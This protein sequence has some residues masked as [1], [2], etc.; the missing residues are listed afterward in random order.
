MRQGGRSS[1]EG[2]RIVCGEVM[3]TRYAVYYAPEPQSALWRFGSAAIGRDAATG[4]ILPPLSGAPFDEPDWHRL[5][6][7]P[8][9]YGFH[10]TL[11]APFRLGDGSN[12]E[13]LR[14]AATDLAARQAPIA[15]ETMDVVCLG[16]FLALV[17]TETPSA[18]TSLASHCVRSLDRFR[19][20]LTDV[21]RARRLAAPLTGRQV[22]YLEEWG[23]PFVFEDFRFHMTLSGP[24]PPERR[25]Q[26]R[27]AVARAYAHIRPGIS[28]DALALFRQNTLAEDFR[29][30][31]RFPFAA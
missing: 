20:P 5:T 31:A 23:Y 8:R 29:V 9:R 19:A 17:P 13:E 4:M 12:E 3:S 7:E 10:A 25:E 1:V 18:L 28:V 27:A 16:S 22:R 24:L 6:A 14:E 30:I 2:R 11:K 21:E 26:G 15:I